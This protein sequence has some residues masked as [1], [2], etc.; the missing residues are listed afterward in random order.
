MPRRLSKAPLLLMH[1]I[2]KITVGAGDERDKQ[3]LRVLATR[4]VQSGEE[5][6]LFVISPANSNR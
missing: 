6:L 4:L 2:E 3:R 1:L 5:W